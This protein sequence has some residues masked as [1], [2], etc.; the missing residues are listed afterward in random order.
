MNIADYVLI[1]LGFFIVIYIVL[2]VKKEDGDRAI[3]MDHNRQ[4]FDNKITRTRDLSYNAGLNRCRFIV[5]DKEKVIYVSSK[6]SGNQL[7]SIPYNEIM[8][9]SINENDMEDG[10]L[11]GAVI[12]GLVAGDIGAYLGATRGSSYVN[13]Y[14]ITIYRSSIQQP[15]ITMTLLDNTKL[16]KDSPAYNDAVNFAT[17]VCS[18]INIISSRT[19][20]YVC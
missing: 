6:E 9:A 15:Q 14:R 3:S 10:S 2:L 17:E 19:N 20:C 18:I 8:Y 16:R 12:G 13:S 7:I 5:D 1:F 4:I 11:G